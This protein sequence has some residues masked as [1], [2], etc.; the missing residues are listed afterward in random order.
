MSVTKRTIP[1][2]WLFVVAVT[3]LLEACVRLFDLHDSI[4]T[5]SSTFRA[6]AAGISSGTLSGELGTTM[7]TY[8]EGLG[9]AIVAGVVLGVVIGSSRTLL[10][11]SSV[12]IEFLRPIP[13]VALIPLAILVVR[14]RRSDAQVRD[15]V[16]RR[17]AHSRQHALRRP[18]HRS[19]PARRGPD[20]GRHATRPPRSRDAAG[21]APEH[22]DR[23][24]GERLDR[25][26]RRRDD[27]VRH[28]HGRHRRLH[29]AS[30][31]SP[32]RFRSST[33]RSSWS[34]RSATRST[35]CSGTSSGASCS[36]SASNGVVG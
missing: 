29:A 26:P 27:R 15:R 1:V 35:P 20:V 23:R 21:R 31:S 34:G 24:P 32:T 8:A 14:P 11:A 12:V 7:E 36:G 13:A 6:L 3:V 17:L 18:R 9:L 4:A 16:R 30:S 19:G 10:D 5:P 2:G 25:A 33:P 22:C 28:R